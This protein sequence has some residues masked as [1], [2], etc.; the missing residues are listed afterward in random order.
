MIITA[1]GVLLLL[2]H[3]LISQQLRGQKKLKDY[4]SLFKLCK[5]KQTYQTDLFTTISIMEKC[6]EGILIIISRFVCVLVHIHVPAAVFT[7]AAPLFP[8]L[9]VVIHKEAWQSVCKDSEGD[10]QQA[11][12]DVQTEFTFLWNCFP[13]DIINL[14]DFRKSSVD[15]EH[16]PS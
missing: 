8:E 3:E 14:T 5:G 15:S 12:M 2:Y 6:F 10:C 11:H 13:F 1:W 9:L 4:D 16:Q 7:V